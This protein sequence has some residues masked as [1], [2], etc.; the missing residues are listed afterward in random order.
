MSWV[1]EVFL[2]VAAITTQPAIRV[3][4]PPP[5]THTLQKNHLQKSMESKQQVLQV[6]HVIQGQATLD[7]QDRLVSLV[8]R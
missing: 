3:V 6:T 4:L 7:V 5:Q 2:L 1:G 8:T